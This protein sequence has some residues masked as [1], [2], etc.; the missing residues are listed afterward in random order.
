MKILKFIKYQIRI[1][2]INSAVSK[3]IKEMNILEKGRDY[4]DCANGLMLVN[5]AQ[6]LND[7]SGKLI[8]D[9]EKILK[10]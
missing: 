8:D 1:I 6:K 9:C 2:R 7:Y 3:I 4:E 10:E 5:I